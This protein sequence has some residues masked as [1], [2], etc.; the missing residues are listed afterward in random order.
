MFDSGM[1][2]LDITFQNGSSKLT[3]EL[4]LNIKGRLHYD[5][6][7]RAALMLL[8]KKKGV[9]QFHIAQTQLVWRENLLTH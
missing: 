8:E 9:S 6:A 3:E 5:K 4:P 1:W 2:Y 7:H